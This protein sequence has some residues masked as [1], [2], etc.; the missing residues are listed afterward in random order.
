MQ[1]SDVQ[2]GLQ[3]RIQRL[4]QNVAKRAEKGQT[5]GEYDD[6]L[7]FIGRRFP[8]AWLQI[9][10]LYEERGDTDAARIALQQ[11]LENSVSDDDRR[12]AWERLANL[13]KKMKA[14]ESE[15]HALV[16]IAEI[17]NTWYGKLSEVALRVNE[18]LNETNKPMD[19]EEKEQLVGRLIALM[20]SRLDE[21]TATDHSRVAWLMLNIND[22]ESARSV[23]KSGLQKDV[24]DFHCNRLAKRLE[25]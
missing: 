14:Y 18:I 3:P 8:P 19:K 9:A 10:S 23:V 1:E 17:P 13:F 7:A 25:I 11:Y 15:L 5:I 16:E 20:K 22:S 2:Y 21:A 24:T 4:I 6:I 12:K